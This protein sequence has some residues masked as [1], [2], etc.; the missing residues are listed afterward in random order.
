[1]KKVKLCAS[2]TNTDIKAVKE[3]EPLVDLFEVRIDIIGEGW[4][5]VARQLK[6]PW[7]ACNRMVE[8]GGKWDGNEARRIERLLQATELGATIVDIEYNAKNVDNIIRFIRKR[9][10][11]LLSFH[12]FQKTPSLDTLKQIVQSEL[13]AGADICKVVTTSKDFE[14]NLTVLKLITEFPKTRILSFAMGEYGL[15]SRIMAPMVGADFTYGA[16]RKGSE[17]APGQLP[18]TEMLKF[19]EIL[20]A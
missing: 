3:V 11:C 13:K 15:M 2:I 14:D 19:Y 4:V 20:T 1:M 8:E 12:D 10:T 16:V 6:K 18:I 7:I 17:S 5:E 9:A